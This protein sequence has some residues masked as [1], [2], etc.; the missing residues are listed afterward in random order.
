MN[1]VTF[2]KEMLED[3]QHQMNWERGQIDYLG[4]DSFDNILRKID[5]VICQKDN[6][7][8][9]EESRGLVIE[10]QVETLPPRPPPTVDGQIEREEMF[11]RRSP[12]KREPVSNAQLEESKLSPSKKGQAVFRRRP[13]PM[14]GQGQLDH[15]ERYVRQPRARNQQPVSNAD[16]DALSSGPFIPTDS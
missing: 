9:T 12:R 16:L 4:V 2:T 5:T 6:G 1:L 8:V 10:T 14:R 3:H 13:K 15:R 7:V 11:V